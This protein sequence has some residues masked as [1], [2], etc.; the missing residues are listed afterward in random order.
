[1][2]AHPP[3]P[4]LHRCIELL[5]KSLTK[6]KFPCRGHLRKDW[7]CDQL[8][9]GLLGDLG[10]WDLKYKGDRRE[11]IFLFLDS[12]RSNMALL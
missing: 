6:G 5:L 11:R 7:S 2:L 8:W 1:M 3:K 10:L 4:I 12:R 9:G